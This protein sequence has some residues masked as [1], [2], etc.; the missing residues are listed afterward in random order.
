MK[1]ESGEIPLDTGQETK[2]GC[3]AHGSNSRQ[4]GKSRRGCDSTTLIFVPSKAP[5]VRA[6]KD[7]KGDVFTIGSGNKGKDE[8]GNVHL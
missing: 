3:G 2:A 6:C 1:R 7:L 4:G 8:D 5:E